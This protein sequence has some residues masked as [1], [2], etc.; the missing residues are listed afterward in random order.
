[1]G[2]KEKHRAVGTGCYYSGALQR[3]GIVRLFS[4]QQIRPP[5]LRPSVR[6]FGGFTLANRRVHSIVRLFS[7]IIHPFT[8]SGRQCGFSSDALRHSDLCYFDAYLRELSAY[9]TVWILLAGSL[10]S[11]CPSM[12]SGK[13]APFSGR[14]RLNH[15]S[16]VAR[17]G[18]K[19]AG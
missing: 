8:Q 6:L 10:T 4:G 18:A 5:Y 2:S 9:F 1:M 11:T 14:I 15:G 17:W 7:G 19:L 3:A 16:C 13:T 12:F